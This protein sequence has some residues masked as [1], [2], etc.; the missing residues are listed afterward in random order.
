MKYLAA[1]NNPSPLEESYD[2]CLSIF[3]YSLKTAVMTKSF[4]NIR[5][6]SISKA[7]LEQKFLPYTVYLH[8]KENLTYI[9]LVIIFITMHSSIHNDLPID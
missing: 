2:L 9:F 5:V 6:I 1:S 8:Q 7:I 3:K 4:R